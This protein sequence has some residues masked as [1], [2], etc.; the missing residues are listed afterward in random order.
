MRIEE[1]NRPTVLHMILEAT[2]YPPFETMLDPPSQEWIRSSKP[3]ADKAASVIQ[4]QRKAS[5]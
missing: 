3:E 5:S 4:F 2:K 1:E